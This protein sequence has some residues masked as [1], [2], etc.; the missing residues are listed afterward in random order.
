MESPEN[1]SENRNTT[2]DAANHSDSDAN[3]ASESQY[4]WD[5]EFLY[6]FR[7]NE[8]PETARLLNQLLVSDLNYRN[9]QG[10][11]ALH[12]TCAN[13]LDLAT[14]YLLKGL[15]V[16]YWVLNLSGNSPL[17]WAVQNKCVGAMKVLLSHDYDVNSSRYENKDLEKRFQEQLSQLSLNPRTIKH[18]HLEEYGPSYE[19]D[20]AIDILHKN[21]FGKSILSEAFDCNDLDVLQLI[22]EHPVSAAMATAGAYTGTTSAVTSEAA[23][24]IRI[25]ELAIENDRILNA[26]ESELDLSGQII[27]EASII[28]AYWLYNTNNSNLFRSKSV[29]ELGAGCGLLGIALWVACEHHGQLPGKLTLTDL[30]ER[31]LG[32]IRHNLALNG[33]SAGPKSRED[34]DVDNYGNQYSSPRGEEKYDVII[35]SDL[36]YDRDLVKP[37]VNVIDQLLEGLFLYT[38][39]V[40]RD[41]ADLFVEELKKAGFVVDV[42]HVS[43][44]F[45]GNPFPGKSKWLKVAFF[46]VALTVAMMDI[47]SY[48]LENKINDFT[49]GVV[50][51]DTEEETLTSLESKVDVYLSKIKELDSSLHQNDNKYEIIDQQLKSFVSVEKL[52]KSTPSNR[53]IFFAGIPLSHSLQLLSALKRE[54]QGR[55]RVEKLQS[56]VKKLTEEVDSLNEEKRVDFYRFECSVRKAVAV[57]MGV[58]RLV[59][60]FENREKNALRAFI[61]TLRNANYAFLTLSLRK[62]NSQK[63][64]RF[65][66]L[67]STVVGRRVNYVLNQLR[68]GSPKDICTPAPPKGVL[69]ESLIT[70]LVGASTP[71]NPGST[72]MDDALNGDED[73]E[74]SLLVRL[75]RLLEEE[76][77]MLA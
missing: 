42:Q 8:L 24:S 51:Q 2:M 56:Q 15:K 52:H 26:L 12:F 22:L 73:I 66:K 50:N 41:G 36:V 23:T 31:T 55:E 1:S 53:H 32:N 70:K 7:T 59:S 48:G 33:L 4:S 19:A 43:G 47:E 72:L 65:V 29:L 18:Y 58:S 74:K 37:L 46:K 38:Y 25:R 60:L 64:V 34:A 69:H 62:M 77:K 61:A 44:Q 63:A 21:K 27:W 11:T 49:R 30:S 68:R 14:Y 10:N 71:V 13:N 35:A 28:A 40:S 67:L 54:Q 3:D 57:G 20:N 16:N 6:S 9:D 39:K 45:Q 75:E 17:Q 5:E 76:M